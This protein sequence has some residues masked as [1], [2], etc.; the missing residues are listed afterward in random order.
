MGPFDPLG[1]TT[2]TG[3]AKEAPRQRRE[4]QIIMLLRIQ[5]SYDCSLR[6]AQTGAECCDA[7]PNDQMMQSPMVSCKVNF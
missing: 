2:C 4:I 5:L 1:M 7:G 3:S 6:L